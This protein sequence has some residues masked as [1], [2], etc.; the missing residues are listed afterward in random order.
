TRF[1]TFYGCTAHRDVMVQL[2]PFDHPDTLPSPDPGGNFHASDANPDARYLR[3]LITIA[4]RRVPAGIPNG[5]AR[6]QSITARV[7]TDEEIETAVATVGDADAILL[8]LLGPFGFEMLKGADPRH[9]AL[10]AVP[11]PDEP[12][13]TNDSP[14]VAGCVVGQ[15]PT[16]SI[17]TSIIASCVT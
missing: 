1:V 16:V 15:A 10:L 12:P 7:W 8:R 17:L 3:G 14:Y 5:I 13:N 2:A 6:W 4:V 9:Y 11:L